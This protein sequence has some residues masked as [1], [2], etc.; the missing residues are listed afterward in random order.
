MS[1]D[2]IFSQNFLL[3]GI[4]ATPVWQDLSDA[5]IRLFAIIRSLISEILMSKRNHDV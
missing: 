3:D 1:M 4:K 5:P 2:G